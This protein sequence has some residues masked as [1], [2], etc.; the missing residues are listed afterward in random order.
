[1]PTQNPIGR[2]AYCAFAFNSAGVYGTEVDISASPRAYLSPAESFHI[3]NTKAES[4]FPVGAN[5]RFEV[6]EVLGDVKGEFT[7]KMGMRYHGAGPALLAALIGTDTVTTVDTTAKKHAFAWVDSSVNIGTVALWFGNVSGT[8]QVLKSCKLTSATLDAKSKGP[9]T[10]TIKG[11]GDEVITNSSLNTIAAIS[12]IPMSAD[13]KKRLMM[14]WHASTR[15]GKNAGFLRLK[16]VTGAEGNCSSS[17]TVY[18][19]SWKMSID[20]KLK[21]GDSEEQAALEPVEDGV[22]VIKYEIDVAGFEGNAGDRQGKVASLV[23]DLQTQQ[24]TSALVYKCDFY[25]ESPDIAGSTTQKYAWKLQ[26]PECAIIIKNPSLDKMGL[27]GCK[28]DVHAMQAQTAPN[29]SDWTALTDP[30]YMT[31]WN[32]GATSYLA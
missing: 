18:A 24:G 3:G 1:M 7:L 2:L 17:D 14:Y 8:Y 12:A 4:Q 22:P 9:V 23:Q 32:L 13:E 28:L 19:S 25:F 31:F 10:L 29:G 16:K 20:R 21:Q 5:L 6:V 26:S 27:I 30:F 11:V 15:S